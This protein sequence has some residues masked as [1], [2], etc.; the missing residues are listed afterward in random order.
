MIA[1]SNPFSFPYAEA[2]M[3]RALLILSGTFWERAIPDL[4]W[5][6]STS[7]VSQDYRPKFN[8]ESY[9]C[10]SG[11]NN[12]ITC[13]NTSA[14]HVSI[15]YENTDLTLEFYF[16]FIFYF[17]NHYSASSAN[18]MVSWSFI[19]LNLQKY[20]NLTWVSHTVFSHWHKIQSKLKKKKKRVPTHYSSL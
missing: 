20:G 13:M 18:C 2:S 19:W 6:V 14:K 1:G 5:D 3:G 10:G 17:F 16:I 12:C 15:A 11:E 8:F 4:P 7:C 9:V